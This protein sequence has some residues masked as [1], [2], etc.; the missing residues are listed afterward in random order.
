MGTNLY[1]LVLNQMA[2]KLDKCTNSDTVAS[3]HFRINNLVIK[4]KG[5]ADIN[6]LSADL[7]IILSPQSKRQILPYFLNVTGN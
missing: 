6:R 2:F 3:M 7:L 5:W 1:P 4:K